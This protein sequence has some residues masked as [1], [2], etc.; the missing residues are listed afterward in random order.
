MP[1]TRIG[2]V[3]VE[4][5]DGKKMTIL[6]N[7]IEKSLGLAPTEKSKFIWLIYNEQESNIRKSLEKHYDPATA[8]ALAREFM[9]YD[10]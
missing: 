6:C 8:R 5:A 2:A 10:S 1:T 3:D 7:R 9:M 4:F